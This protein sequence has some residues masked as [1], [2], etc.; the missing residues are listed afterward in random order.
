MSKKYIKKNNFSPDTL[1][2]PGSMDALLMP[3]NCKNNNSGF[4]AEMTE[5]ELAAELSQAE[6]DE[7]YELIE[8]L[9]D[10]NEKDN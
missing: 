9:E 2:K 3:G 7:L 10:K 1:K 5:E 6:L 8:E 4:F